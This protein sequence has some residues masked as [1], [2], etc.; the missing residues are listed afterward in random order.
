V[1]TLPLIGGLVVL[2]IWLVLVF[3]RGGFWSVRRHFL[4]T[5]EDEHRPV[6]VCVIV[7]AR[8]EVDTIA[9]TVT[10]LLRQKFNGTLR[11][12]IVDDDSEDQTAAVATRAAE[13]IGRRD[14]LTVITGMPLPEGWTGKLWA[15]S[16]GL[17]EAQAVSP[18]YLLL[19]DADIEHGPFTISTLVVKAE[20]EQL[21]LT[22]LMV[23]LHCRTLAE[24]MMI[25]AF[26]YFF[27]LLYPPRWI[28][29]RQTRTA[30]AA[31]GCMLVRPDAL[32]RA[33][34]I[35]SIR[36]E[37]IDDCALAKAIKGSGGRIWLGL[38]DASS[39]LRPYETVREIRR[40]IERTAFNQLKHSTLLLIGT[41]VGLLLTFVL[42]VALLLSGS[43][44][45]T[46]LAAA[47]IVLMLASYLSMVLY[48][49]L[50]PMWSLA[51]PV[52]ACVYLWATLQSAWNFYR[53][54]GGQWKGRA[55]DAKKGDGIQKAE[56]GHKRH[57]K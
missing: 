37:V 3:A 54:R 51:L 49:R 44:A 29:N 31:G 9:R 20:R 19:T 32:A 28:A 50:L 22:S 2:T 11:L 10:A 23:R 53:G 8:N 5:C 38:A 52:S 25:P 41:V 12:I 40:M 34:G 6:R 46:V 26:V 30:G 14:A 56:E 7:P 15:I 35:E 4:P 21:A 24:K 16:Q 43:P 55:Q 17:K 45:A 42:P 48:Y 39:S 1:L 47:A 57:K 36:G 33:A 18:D 13:V 27:F